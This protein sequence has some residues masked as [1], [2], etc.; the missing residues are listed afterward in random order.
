[1]AELLDFKCP[2]CGGAINFDSQAQRMKCPYCGT[3]FDMDTVIQYEEALKTEPERD[4]FDW[5]LKAD[6]NWQT[7]EVNNVAVYVC[8][9]CGGQIVGDY[10]TSATSCP[11]CD[12]PVVIAGNVSGDLRPDYIIPFKLTKEQAKQGLRDLV[13]GKRLLP[14]LFKDE[15]RIDQIRGMYVPFWLFDTDVN[16]NFRYKATRTNTWSD[17]NYIYTKTSYYSILRSGQ[18]AFNSVPVDASSKLADDLMESIEPYYVQDLVNFNA[19]YLAGYLADRYDVPAEECTGRANQRVRQST[20]KKFASTVQGYQ[21][22]T[23][24]NS[25]VQLSK[26]KARYVLYPVWILNTTWD[27]KQYTFAMNGQTGRFIGDLP[28]DKKAYWRWFGLL[29]LVFFIVSYAAAWLV[30]LLL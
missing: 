12:N 29:A 9:S 3:E 19:G 6:A 28:L 7:D 14:K 5:D 22:V 8:Q 18:L 20:E 15:N 27:D 16:G 25:S 23:P 30:H 17:R 21:T 11:Y 4:N 13:Q 26:G 2:S 24:E 1:M 10:T